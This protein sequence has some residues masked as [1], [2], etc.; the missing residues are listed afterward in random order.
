LLGLYSKPAALAQGQGRAPVPLS[1]NA[2]ISI[3]SDGSVK[4]MAK[5]PE[6]G[7]GVKNLLPM[8]IAEELD[9]DWKDVKVEQA[10]LNAK[11]GGQF[12]GGSQ[13]TPSGWDPMRQ[14]GAAGRQM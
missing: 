8:M 9:V 11:Y 3:A 2:F 6:V 14:V 12:S 4:I 5:A 13:A 10:D 1:P 7:Q